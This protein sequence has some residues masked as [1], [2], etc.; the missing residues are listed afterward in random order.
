MLAALHSWVPYEFALV[1]GVR[2]AVESGIEGT[3]ATRPTVARGRRGRPP[4]K[5]RFLRRMIGLHHAAGRLLVP[6][7]LAAALSGLWMTPSSRG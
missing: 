2:R 7:G 5:V 6:C 4:P 1:G 3:P